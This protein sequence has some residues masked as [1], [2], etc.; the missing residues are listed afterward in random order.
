VAAPTASLLA[1]GGRFTW[2]EA[3]L[4]LVPI[5]VFAALL[6]LANRRANALQAA[7]LERTPA[8]D[9]APAGSA[10]EAPPEG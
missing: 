10:P 9:A 1:H 8:D 2:D 6:A 7:R 3:L 4:V 5:V